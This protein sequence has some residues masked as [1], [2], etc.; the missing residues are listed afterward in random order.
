M[1]GTVSDLG[2]RPSLVR[3][4]RSTAYEIAFHAGWHLSWFGDHQSRVEKLSHSAHQEWDHVGDRIGTE[5]VEQGLHLNGTQLIRRDS[6]A[7]RWVN[8]GRA[9]VSWTGETSP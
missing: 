4:K 9:P 2:T 3:A 6:D 5:Y 8:E 1:I 7:P